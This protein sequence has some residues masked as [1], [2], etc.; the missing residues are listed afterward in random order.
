MNWYVKALKQYTDFKGRARRKEY[1]MFLLFHLI[2]AY[3]LNITAL[4]LESAT[5]AIV[6]TVYLV[7]TL[8][9][10]IAVTVRR[11]HDTGNSGWFMLIPFYNLILACT[12]SES[13]SNKWGANP[14]TDNSEIDEIGKP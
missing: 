7:A 3:G 12:N 2:T 5:L 8:I 13:G 4:V 10:L 1:W 9:P 6:G 11:M 14:K